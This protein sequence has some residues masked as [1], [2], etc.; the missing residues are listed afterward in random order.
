MGWIAAGTDY[1]VTLE[2]GKVVSRNAAGKVLRSVPAAIKEHD[3]VVGL[4]QLAEWLQRHEESCRA[5]VD[6]W[7]VR[8]LPVPMPLLVQVWADE[9]WRAVLA[10]L[11]VAPVGDDGSWDLERGG[12][13]RDVDADK[14]MGLVNLDGESVR[15]HAD[16]VV[17]PHPVRLADLEDLRDFAAELGVR[18]GTLQLFREVFVKP[19]DP[20]EQRRT[21]TRYS[22]AQFKELRHVQARATTLGYR[23]QGGTSSLRMWEEGKPLTASVWIGDGEPYYETSTG[24]LVFTDANGS[25]I[26]LAEVPVVT[27]SEGVRM[28]AALHAGRVVEQEQEGEAQ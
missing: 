5:E 9:A 26:P 16:Q 14:G 8:S 22:G 11:V 17:I 19:G 25:S 1:E 12:L 4:R 28:A 18:Q 13:L 7:M 2:G 3:T 15:R 23:V 27:W 10:D 21:V 6:R 20:E 24:D